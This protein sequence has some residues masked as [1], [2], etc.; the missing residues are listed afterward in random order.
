MSDL[1]DVVGHAITV[2]AWRSRRS[3]RYELLSITRLSLASAEQSKE[4]LRINQLSS[5][6]ECVMLSMGTKLASLK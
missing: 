4:A 2:A 1:T 6:R 5:V 3:W